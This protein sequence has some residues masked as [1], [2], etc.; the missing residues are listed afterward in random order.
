ML[1]H[2][3]VIWGYRYLL[4]RVPE[5][6]KTIESHAHL[7]ADWRAFRTALLNSAE[8]RQLLHGT[9]KLT[10]KWVAADVFAG[11]RTMW[12]DLNDDYVSRGCLNDSYEPLETAFVKANLGQGDIFLDIGANI[13]WFTLLATTLIGDTGRVHAF[14][15]RKPTVDYLRRSIALNG[16]NSIVTVHEV[17]LDLEERDHCLA[18]EKGTTNPG[19]SALCEGGAGNEFETM[20]IHVTALDKIGLAKVDF[21]KID[22]EGAEMNV[23]LGG[24]KTITTHRPV[25]LS[26]LYPDQLKC[27]SHAT[28]NDLFE[29]FRAMNYRAFIIDTVRCGDEITDFPADWRKELVNVVIIPGERL[30]DGR[31]SM[32]SLLG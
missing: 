15:P 9:R 6:A 19:H 26:E 1:T 21:I 32:P 12:L 28:P 30:N 11:K 7:Y 25:I 10:P 22:V 20:A 2:D 29:H 18:W 8:F 24:A 31:V 16:L 14:E 13:G 27:V 17:G 3:E 23:F 5:S 4:G